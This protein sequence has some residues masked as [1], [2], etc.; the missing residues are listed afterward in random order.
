M[1]GRPP[2]IT[3]VSRLEEVPPLITEVSGLQGRPLLIT[4][5]HVRSATRQEEA[6]EPRVSRHE[7]AV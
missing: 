4:E 7:G 5:E 2:L 1:E 6:G 3:E